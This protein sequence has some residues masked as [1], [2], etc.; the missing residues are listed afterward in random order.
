MGE[1]AEIYI[2]ILDPEDEKNRIGQP[3]DAEHLRGNLYRIVSENTD[4]ENEP[5][6]FQTGDKVRCVRTRFEDGS[7]NLWAYA[8]MDDEDRIVYR[9]KGS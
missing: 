3:V 4:P 8:K 5:W 2:C 1:L 7:V 9:S 6:E